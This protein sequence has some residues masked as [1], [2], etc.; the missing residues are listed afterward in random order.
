MTRTTDVRV[1]IV[2]PLP[3]RGLLTA[4]C[5]LLCRPASHE[6]GK[7][8]TQLEQGR[9]SHSGSKAVPTAWAVV[10]S[11]AQEL[12]WAELCYIECRLVVHSPHVLR[13]WE[14]IA[15]WLRCESECSNRPAHPAAPP[16]RG[17]PRRLIQAARSYRSRADECH[18]PFV[19]ITPHASRVVIFHGHRHHD[20]TG[21]KGDVVL[22]PL[23]R[24]RWAR[25]GRVAIE[26]A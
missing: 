18:G 19:A 12:A 2:S 1:R 26:A 7:R 9:R 20:W 6:R 3:S 25:S 22:A 8:A 10:S 5:D 24:S 13:M 11:G 21:T 23:R 14:T 17:V 16:R 15:S 4:Y